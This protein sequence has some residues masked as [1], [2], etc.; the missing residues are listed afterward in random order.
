MLTRVKQRAARTVVGQQTEQQRTNPA[1]FNGP[2][3]PAMSCHLARV[4]DEPGRGDEQE[5]ESEP[6]LEHGVRLIHRAEGEAT[7]TQLCTLGECEHVQLN[8]IGPVR[9]VLGVQ[10]RDVIAP[11]AAQLTGHVT[12]V[13]RGARTQHLPRTALALLRVDGLVESDARVH[14]CHVSLV[15]H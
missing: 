9:E 14:I 12:T 2:I 10:Q 8:A 13:R 15:V 4:D 1:L 7:V 3:S 11:L 6:Q 5:H